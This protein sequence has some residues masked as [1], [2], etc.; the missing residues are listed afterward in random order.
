MGGTR[1][2]N[3]IA[4]IAA[5]IAAAMFVSCKNDLAEVDALMAAKTQPATVIDTFAL[6]RVDSGKVV[7]RMHAAQVV[8]EPNPKDAS[9]TDRK[10]SGGVEI[11]MYD[12][13][14]GAMSARLSAEAQPSVSPSGER[15][16]RIKI[17]SAP[18]R[19]CAA[20]SRFAISVTKLSGENHTQKHSFL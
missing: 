11:E 1:I 16:L 20:S 17:L 7:M 9:L 18:R 4:C 2:N 6:V 8:M 14:T 19:K 13:A 15:W 3:K 10:A 12:P 5:A